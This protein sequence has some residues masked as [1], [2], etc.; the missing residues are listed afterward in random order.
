MMPHTRPW[1][2]WM[3]LVPLAL[4][5]A[6]VAVLWG[7]FADMV[8]RRSLQ[9]AATQVL[10]TQVDI[11]WL[12]IRE[13]LAAVE[14]GELAVADP[15]DPT[16]NLIEVDRIRLVLDPGPLLEKKIVIS[17]LAFERIDLFTAREKPANPVEG[18]L[19][20]RTSSMVDQW[21]DRLAEPFLGLSAVDSISTLVLDPS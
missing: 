5:F 10:G 4:F 7:L 14:I 8:A 17:D 15:F 1:F 11:G 6:F 9:E 12:R 2:R 16:R 19:A 18:G 13:R 21:R 20:A 3:A